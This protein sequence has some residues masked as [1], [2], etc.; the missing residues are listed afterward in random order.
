MKQKFYIAKNEI[1]VNNNGLNALEILYSNCKKRY[2][3]LY[4]T[5]FKKNTN[6]I[7]WKNFKDFGKNTSNN[8]KE[9]ARAMHNC[10]N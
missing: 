8:L 10:N 5:G 9:T 3:I 7:N 1:N 4:R 2:V 6:K